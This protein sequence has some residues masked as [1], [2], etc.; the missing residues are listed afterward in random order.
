MPGKSVKI[1]GTSSKVNE[2]PEAERNYVNAENT[3]KIFQYALLLAGEEEWDQKH[4]GPIHLLKYAYLA[5]LAYARANDGETY[6]GVEWKFHHFGPW[7]PEAYTLVK[8]AAEQIHA[9][10]FTRQSDYETELIR[11]YI[12]EDPDELSREI[13]SFREK[14]PL[15]VRGAIESAV[16]KFKSDTKS[17]LIMVY[18]TLPMLSTAPG[19]GI[20]FGMIAKEP[21]ALYQTQTSPAFV[22]LLDSLSN[23]KRKALPDRL[24][25]LREQMNQRYNAKKAKKTS[26]SIPKVTLEDQQVVDWVDSLA[27]N[28]FPEGVMKVKI[29]PSVWK[30]GSRTGEEWANDVSD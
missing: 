2:P 28:D 3:K 10:T 15:E 22:P 27:G 24:T 8:E 5:D 12:K 26:R 29:D 17:L 1:C 21:Q 19:E 13:R 7:S 9:E 25:H 11:Y 23:K 16:R 6:T 18:S 4:L 30:S 20:D 14:M